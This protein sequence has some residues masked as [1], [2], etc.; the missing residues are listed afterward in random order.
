MVKLSRREWLRAVGR[1]AAAGC[2]MA[3]LPASIRRALAV[4]PNA[5]TGTLQDVQHIVLLMQEN[6]S[7]DHYFG[8]MSGVRGFGDRSQVPQRRTESVFL[9]YDGNRLIA[10]F[11]LDTR[12]TQAMRVEGTPHS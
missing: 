10:P 2:G 9:Q 11:H 12:S 7:F 4:P 1:T 5:V 3:A 8:T 6:R